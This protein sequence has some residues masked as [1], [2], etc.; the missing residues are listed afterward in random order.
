M[1]IKIPLPTANLTFDDIRD[2]LNSGGGS[3]DN[4]TASAFKSTAKINVFSKRKPVVNP[5]TFCQDFD[6]TKPNYYAT[7]WLGIS[8]NAGLNIPAFGLSNLPTVID[9]ELNG[10]SYSLPQGGENAPLRLGDFCGYDAKAKAP[11]EGFTVPDKVGKDSTF[12]VSVIVY[13]PE[14]YSTSLTLNDLPKLKN[15][16]LGVYVTDGTNRDW[17]T[18]DTKVGD[19]AYSVTLSPTAWPTG[20]NWK[21]YLFL[22]EG[23][24]AQGGQLAGP[25]YTI[26]YT[27]EQSFEVVNST[28][29]GRVWGEKIQGT[30]NVTIKCSITFSGNKVFSTNT[31]YVKQTPPNGE[32]AQPGID[33]A[34][35]RYFNLED[36]SYTG[37]GQ[38]QTFT[39]ISNVTLDSSLTTLVLTLDRGAYIIRGSIIQ[40]SP[41]PTT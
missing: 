35:E 40:Y 12:T 3:V 29:T 27:K 20:T 41:T 39:L 5:L 21:A 32:Q 38:P 30:N 33:N 15:Y 14:S 16:Y 10:W 6:S 26:P 34:L 18:S 36:L 13:P 9:G 28:V 8:G 37:G 31:L 24:I 22:C 19:G 11:I 23:K 25:V 1:A 17:G 7:W 4:T 2:T